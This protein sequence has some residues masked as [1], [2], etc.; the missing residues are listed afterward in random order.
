MSKNKYSQKLITLNSEIFKP[1]ELYLQCT[2]NDQCF[3]CDKNIKG[4]FNFPS[5]TKK[6]IVIGDIHGDLESLL[7]CLLKANIINDSFEWIAN[8]TIV[9]QMGDILDRGGRLNSIDTENECEELHII[10]FLEHINNKAQEKGGKMLC[11]LGN[12]E[13]M[14]IFGDFRYT[15]KNTN[16]CFNDRKEIFKQGSNMAKKLAC[17]TYGIIKIDDW[18]FV[19]GGL[20][21]HHLRSYND[22]PNKF[23]Q[24]VNNLTYDIL[25]GIKKINKL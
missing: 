13:L 10:Q 5:K 19:H 1:L 24:Y 14:N 20:L 2:H 16:K 9:I 23:I 17:L 12:H 18:I 11:L 15:S 8:D 22:N 21:P 4:I 6:V 3:T 25:N 7:I